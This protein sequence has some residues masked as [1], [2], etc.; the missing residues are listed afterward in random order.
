MKIV[1]FE[2]KGS[3]HLFKIKGAGLKFTKL[4]I[5]KIFV[6]FGWILEPFIHRKLNTFYIFI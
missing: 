4:E 5:P 1:G 6:T 2:Q 3:Q